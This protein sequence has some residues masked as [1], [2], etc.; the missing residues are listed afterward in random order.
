MTAI[1]TRVDTPIDALAAP[2]ADGEVLVWPGNV[3]L[4][5]E[6]IRN[7][8]RLR[9]AEVLLL[10]RPLSEWRQP[11]GDAAPVIMAG[12]QPDF[13]HSG[14]WV[15]HPAVTQLAAQVG[16]KASYLLVDSD[17]PDRLRLEWPS[18]G[19]HGLQRSFT[20]APS[21]SAGLSFEQFPTVAV[22]AWTKCLSATDPRSIGVMRA[23]ADAFLGGDGRSASRGDY[24]TRWI[25][26]VR[27]VEHSLNLPSPSYVRVSE[28]FDGSSAMSEAALALAAHLVIHAPRF[29]ACY[30]TALAGYRTRR[31]IRGRQHP[32]PDLF[33]SP[34]RV[35]LPFWLIDQSGPRQ[36]LHVAHVGDHMAQLLAVDRV[37]ATIELKQIRSNPRELILAMGVDKGIRPRALAVTMFAR[38]LACDLFIH[39]IGGAKYDQITDGLIRAFFG[40]EPPTYACVSATLRLPL[41]VHAVTRQDVLHARRLLRDI[42]YNPQRFLHSPSDSDHHPLESERARAIAAARTLAQHSPDDHRAR[43]L[44]FERIRELNRS[45]YAVLP[46][47]ESELRGRMTSLE[48]RLRHNALA[49]SREWFFALHAPARLGGLAEAVRDRMA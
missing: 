30:N 32:I 40:V 12:H 49:L 4:A 27:A 5:Q 9:K 2:G 6:A 24:V 23:F 42:R 36:R 46:P 13:I 43:R 1:P 31:G 11:H 7:R 34:E 18:M 39:G 19:E 45:L 41:Q 17:V 14:V 20:L 33:V 38:L 26:G 44:A 47:V 37:V 28:A 29:A 16:G 48:E 22:D 25:S 8:E 35:E 15:K 3:S 10:D 21:G